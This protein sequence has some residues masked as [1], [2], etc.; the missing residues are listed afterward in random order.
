MDGGD[1]TH[2]CTFVGFVSLDIFIHSALVDGGT[3]LL[4][5]FAM[6]SFLSASI[7]RYEKLPHSRVHSIKYGRLS[8]IC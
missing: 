8:P 6:F 4:P 7:P 2:S 1:T 3:S 5:C